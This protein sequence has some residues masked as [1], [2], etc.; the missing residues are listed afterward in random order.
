MRATGSASSLG[1]GYMGEFYSGLVCPEAKATVGAMGIDAM[2]DV[3]REVSVEEYEKIENLRDTI[4]EARD[5]VP[6]FSVADNW[7]DKHYKKHRLLYLKE[8]K[9]FYRTYEWSL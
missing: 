6:D 4:I 7:F 9:D 1:S 2:L 5:F 8:V 3:R